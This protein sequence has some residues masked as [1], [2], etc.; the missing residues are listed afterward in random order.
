MDLD[1][2]AN[3]I[4]TYLDELR[5]PARQGPIK[6]G[7]IVRPTGMTVLDTDDPS[8]AY[9]FTAFGRIVISLAT[10]DCLL[11]VLSVEGDKLR[12]FNLYSGIIGRLDAGSV[13][14]SSLN[15]P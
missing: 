2:I 13:R 3:T 11:L 7:T 6:Q 12:V 4:I 14:L 8:A 15:D 9:D 10:P 1:K 5:R